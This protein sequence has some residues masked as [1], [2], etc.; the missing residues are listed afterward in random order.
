MYQAKPTKT[1]LYPVPDPLPAYVEV[2][3]FKAGLKDASGLARVFAY[4]E[5]RRGK[6]YDWIGVLTAGFIEVGGLEFCS[7]LTEDAFLQYPYT[8]CPDVRF[9]TPDDIANSSLLF[10]I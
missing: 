2:W 4:A 8:L 9:T 5:S 7:Q 3:R 1:D 10:K 6:L